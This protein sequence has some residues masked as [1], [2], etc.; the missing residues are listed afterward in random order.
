MLFRSS[1]NDQGGNDQDLREQID[2]LEVEVMNNFKKKGMKEQE[3]R[4][5]SAEVK[6]KREQLKLSQVTN[7]KS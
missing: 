4:K 7:I 3:I 5:V 2:L 6:A 1:D